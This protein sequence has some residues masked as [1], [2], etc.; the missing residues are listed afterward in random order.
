MIEQSELVDFELMLKNIILGEFPELLDGLKMEFIT[1]EQ[2]VVDEPDK[3][4]LIY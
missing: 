2:V 3:E 1:V 4:S